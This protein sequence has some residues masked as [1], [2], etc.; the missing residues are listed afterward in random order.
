MSDASPTPPAASFIPNISRR[1]FVAG[2]TASLGA[3]CLSL[4]GCPTGTAQPAT[5][6]LAGVG[7]EI[8]SP[9]D[10]KL[11]EFWDVLIDEWEAQTG[12]TVE[13]TDFEHASATKPRLIFV[14]NL[15]LTAF[16][17]QKKLDRFEPVGAEGS[18]RK[19]DLFNGLKQRL[20]TRDQQ[21]IAMPISQP[22][23]LVYYR[24]DLLEKSGRKVPQT[25]SEYEALVTSRTEWA[26]ELS[27]IEPWG[28]ETR[29]AWLHA[30][31][32]PLLRPVGDYSTWFDI[33]TGE[34]NVSTAVA[35]ACF[36]RLAT[37]WPGLGK[38]SVTLS[39]VEAR[40]KVLRGEAALAIG[41]EPFT[42]PG[43]SASSGAPATEAVETA[44][45]SEIGVALLPATSES[46]EP[47]RKTWVKGPA[48]YRPTL[49][50]FGGWSIGFQ[51]TG[52]GAVGALT[53]L[54]E[55][56][57]DSRAE[58]AF[59]GTTLSLTRESQALDLSQLPTSGLN[60]TSASE[61][62]DAIAQALRSTDVT[63]YLPVDGQSTFIDATNAA[64]KQF[65]AA[66][67]EPQAAAESLV[68][69]FAEAVKMVGADR[70][71]QSYCRSLGLLAD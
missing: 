49:V 37:R 30:Q 52:K 22:V 56:L 13:F 51:G 44:A 9:A 45:T 24:R 3:G 34:S 27:I 61:A 71:K 66:P 53:S 65:F 8:V 1:S 29:A 17:E 32:V 23:F 63:A 21:P 60:G 58:E 42:H 35:E 20:A 68:T 69:G 15:D 57:T 14:P 38:E 64:L 25:W 36:Q 11:A 7:L 39:A 10:W 12:A 26:G 62:F 43:Q 2:M 33:R 4:M 67:E 28:E 6:P 47:R 50:G 40:A 54:W 18:P 59:P 31:L 46:Y 48:D 19:L 55:L 16:D 41:Y 70:V 5:K